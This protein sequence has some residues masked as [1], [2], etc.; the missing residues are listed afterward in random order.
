MSTKLALLLL[1]SAGG[2]AEA[3][4]L[5][6]AIMRRLELIAAKEFL[7]ELLGKGDST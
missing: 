6:Q 2:D 3:T 7:R 1:K 4:K 5:V